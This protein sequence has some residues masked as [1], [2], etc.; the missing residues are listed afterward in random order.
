MQSVH[1]TA[2]YI[3]L[4]E[5]YHEAKNIFTSLSRCT[6]PAIFSTWLLLRFLAKHVC[7]IQKQDGIKQK[8]FMTWH[9][10]WKNHMRDSILSHKRA[11]QYGVWLLAHLKDFVDFDGVVICSKWLFPLGT[12]SMLTRYTQFCST[13]S[14]ALIFQKI[15]YTMCMCICYYVEQK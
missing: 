5:K 15:V 12:K 10:I 9:S 13:L 1:T 4:W 11:S 14:T 3:Q 7:L 6:Y 8:P 2:S